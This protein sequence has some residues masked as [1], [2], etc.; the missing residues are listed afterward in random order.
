M[1]LG[2]LITSL[3]AR[4]VGSINCM[5]LLNL[6]NFHY[7]L[8]LNVEIWYICTLVSIHMWVRCAV[9][10]RS[11]MSRLFVTPCTVASQPPLSMG[12]LQ[13]RILEWVGMPPSRGSSQLRD[14]TQVSTLQADSSPS[15]P[16]GKPKNIGMGS[17]SF[18]QQ[19]CRM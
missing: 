15:E 4:L 12:I 8:F 18:L 16:S 7:T 19:M 2:C 6:C 5:F 14:Q 9:L 3:N 13:A 17:L 11:V 10:S 1:I